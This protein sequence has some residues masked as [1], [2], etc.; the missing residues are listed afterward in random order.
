MLAGIFTDYFFGVGYMLLAG[1]AYLLRDWRQLQ[2]A[3]SAPG[4][5]FFF[6]IW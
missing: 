4:F 5:I 3:I 1:I 2:L 6:Y